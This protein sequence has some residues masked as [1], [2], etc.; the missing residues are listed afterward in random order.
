MKRVICVLFAIILMTGVMSFPSF[1]DSASISLSKSNVPVGSNVTVNVRYSAGF[2]MYAIDASL[3]YN[4]SV[5]QYVSGGT[6]NGSTVKMVETLSGE[7]S[8]SFSVTF[9]AIAAGAGSVSFSAKASGD[10]D[11]SASSGATVTVTAPQPS[12]NA[13]LSSIKLSEGTLS[14][15]FK[16][17]TTKYNA[18]VRYQTEKISI[19][20]NA[21]AGDS[22]VS[23]AG[24]YN[25]KVGDNSFSLT[26]TAASGEKKTYTVIVK[27]MTEEETTAALQ[28]ERDNNPNLIVIDG[29]DRFIQS[30]V[31]ALGQIEGFSPSLVQRKGADIGVLSD[32]AGKYTLYWVTD[33]NGENGAFYTAD[34][35]DNFT[36]LNYIRTND[37]LYIIEPFKENINVSSE[38]V[39]GEYEVDG[40]KIPCY[41]YTD[42]DL[43]DF[44]VFYCYINGQ[45]DYYRFDAAQ[46]TMQR[47]PKLLSKEIKTQVEAKTGLLD[48]FNKLGSQAKIVL[49]L[50]MLAAALIIVLIVLLIIRSAKKSGANKRRSEEG[51]LVLESGF[52]EEN[53]I[54]E[55]EKSESEAGQPEEILDGDFLDTDD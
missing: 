47:E 46:N 27:R 15:A 43:S 14:P 17:A 13:N 36:R 32:N 10:G 38:F 30:D 35:K 45:S 11:G 6:N 34:D 5:L 37:R 16:Q 7:T 40:Q 24:T 44:Y 9:K 51:A 26:V 52:G 18:S 39:V 49:C 55:I 2:A 19:S 28:A 20:A 12:S 41:K 31:S 53:D 1:A 50:I 33:E 29:K 54:V 42:S 25:L 8:K 48:K 23:G 22:T 4:S 21:A 3:T